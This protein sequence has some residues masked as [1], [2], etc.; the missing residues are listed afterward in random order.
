MSNHASGTPKVRVNFRHGRRAGWIIAAVIM[1]ISIGLIVVPFVAPAMMLDRE[2]KMVNKWLRDNLPDGKWEE[3]EWTPAV[4]LQSLYDHRE[5]WLND[6]L[7]ECKLK[8]NEP[9]IQV[10]VELYESELHRL[11]ERGV[12]RICALKYRATNVL[13][14]KSVQEELFDVGREKASMIFTCPRHIAPPPQSVDPD[15]LHWYG[16]KYLADPEFDVEASPDNPRNLLR[17]AIEASK[18]AEKKK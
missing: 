8:K 9:G 10:N 13:G 12:R 15:A 18:A 7:D 16:W 1:A 2:H 6:K 14:A 5:K 4:S 11:R 3:I 17:G